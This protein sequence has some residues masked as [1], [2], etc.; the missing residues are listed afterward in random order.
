MDVINLIN[1]I[2]NDNI[3][4]KHSDLIH[5]SN[6]DS[7]QLKIFLKAWED[8][9]KTRKL[10]LLRKFIFLSEEN[11]ELDFSQIFINLLNDKN[12]EV[13]KLSLE[14]L[15]EY[16]GRE[17]IDPIINLTHKNHTNEVRISAIALLGTFIVHALDKKII[18]RDANKIANQLKSIFKNEKDLNI[19]AQALEAMSPYKDNETNLLINQAYKS[20]HNTLKKSAIFSMGQSNDETWLSNILSELKSNNLSFR[21]EA[22]NAYAKLCNSNNISPISNLLTDDEQ[23]I[24]LASL[25][26]I[27]IIGGENAKK[28][29]KKASKSTDSILSKTATEILKNISFEENSSIFS[30]AEINL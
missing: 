8:I 17:I 20:D 24:R 18:Q 29:L 6:I 11:I 14:G 2:S 9:P 7:N 1:N 4:Y 16:E 5:I 12:S 26:A 10:D 3:P 23:E 15:W 22:I 21:F 30:Q 25:N 19:Q 13:I 27:G 28:L